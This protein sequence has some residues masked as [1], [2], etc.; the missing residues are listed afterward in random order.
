MLFLLN[1]YA[2]PLLW[3]LLLLPFAGC[4]VLLMT[5]RQPGHF[6]G[7]LACLMTLPGLLISAFLWWKEG[8]PSFS[9]PWFTAG[10]RAFTLGF[11]PDAPARSLLLIVHAIGLLVQVF[12]IEYLRTD[13]AR[14]RYFAFVQLFLGTMIGLVLSE[15]L[16]QLYFFWEG[17][18]LSSYLLI[19]FWHTRHTATRAARKAF[20]LNRIGDVSLALG[21]F[22]LLAA[23][24]S[25]RFL[26]MAPL[27]E[28]SWQTL[29]GLL[30][31]GGTVAKSAQFPLQGWLP[32]AMAGPTPVSALIHAATMVAAGVFLL[33]RIYVLLTP[34]ALLIITGVGLLTMLLGGVYALFQTDIKKLLAYSTLSQLG[35][36]VMGM[37]SGAAPAAMFHLYTHA[38]FKA[39]LFLV[40]GSL[41]HRLHHAPDPQDI[42]QMGGLARKM[43]L[44]FAAWCVCAASLAGLPLTSGFLSKDDMLHELL[45]QGHWP[46]VAAL[47]LAIGLTAAYL[48]RQGRLTFCG[49]FRAETS[50]YN[51]IQENKLLITIP[52]LLLAA[53]SIGLVFRPFDPFGA[54][55]AWQVAGPS[56]GCTLAGGYA[57]WRLAG[58]ELATGRFLKPLPTPDFF[59]HEFAVSAAP[60]VT[61]PDVPP[62]V[63]RR[64]FRPLQQLA[65]AAR[66]TDTKL[67]DGLVNGVAQAGLGLAGL[68]AFLEKNLID[69]LVNGSAAAASGW[70]RAMQLLQSG[71]V[72]RYVAGAMLALLGLVWWLNRE[73][74]FF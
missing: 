33:Q 32:D 1:L 31:F 9:H 13:P 4:G 47:L 54:L 12:S 73:L 15:N 2:E 10:G 28:A 51:T 6:A 60:Q 16:L 40:A 3:T 27:P 30:L 21:I 35:L 64:P 62:L 19:G 53:G 58:R 52:L 45:Q 36:M 17:V 5:G 26:L 46:Q 25:P 11:L 55:F 18:G 56:L 49:L 74:I 66:F 34:T 71:R 20:L 68:S 65:V 42:R 38:F 8:V 7:V 57:G 69:G 48:A 22:G 61:A 43:P 50:L 14:H 72:Q 39:G 29:T 24:G 63:L 41:I 23:G 59:H 37:G 70:G 67:L 44:T